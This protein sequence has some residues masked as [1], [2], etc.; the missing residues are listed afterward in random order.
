MATSGVNNFF[1]HGFNY[2]YGAGSD[3]YGEEGWSP[4]P[5]TG[6]NVTKSNTL[7]PYFS[8]MNAYASRANYLMQQG[9]ASKDVA[10]YMPF[11]GSLSETDAV[12]AMNYNGYTW[13]A[14]NDD[15][16]VSADTQYT[17]G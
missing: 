3:Q 9:K 17:G 4:M 10:L 7:S 12:K 6:I 13:D 16:I 5:T 2:R 11:N 14:V 1:Y 8:Q 15:S